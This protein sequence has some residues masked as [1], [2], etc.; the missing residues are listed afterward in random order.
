MQTTTTNSPDYKVSPV[1][2]LQIDLTMAGILELIRPI[3]PERAAEFDQLLRR[4]RRL[5]QQLDHCVSCGQ[6][7]PGRGSKQ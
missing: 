6:L 2:T 4:L 1:D 7:L 3:T 5:Y